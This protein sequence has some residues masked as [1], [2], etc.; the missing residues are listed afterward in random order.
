MSDAPCGR[1]WDAAYYCLNPLKRLYIIPANIYLIHA[2]VGSPYL[3]IY[4]ISPVSVNEW[5][6]CVLGDEGAHVVNWSIHGMGDE[7]AHV[8]NWDIDF[9]ILSTVLK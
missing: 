5:S 4:S 7:G 1:I 2:P 3:S 8:V 9:S 6:I